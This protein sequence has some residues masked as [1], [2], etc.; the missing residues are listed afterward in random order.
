MRFYN[1][2]A[3]T[4]KSGDSLPHWEQ[5]GATYFITFRLGDSIPSDIL[6]EWKMERAAWLLAH[7]KPWSETVE[8][9][10]H[11]RFSVRVDEWLDLGSGKC[12]LRH[13]ENR[14]IL[15]STLLK[16]HGSNYA[17]H[18]FVI[19]PNH[20]HLLAT[21][22]LGTLADHLQSWKGSSSF[23]INRRL[24]LGG[25][26]WQRNY[27]DRMIRDA[28]HYQRCLRYIANNPVKAKLG[29]AAFTHWIGG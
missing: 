29:P 27:F 15:S 28:R 10:Y 8:G 19:M 6:E 14:E 1:S 21:I 16:D 22:R 26:F 3:I 23:Q 20:V 12:L 24:G 7:P 4:L 2:S 18:A 25:S 17:M 9:E 5:T 13:P 11:R